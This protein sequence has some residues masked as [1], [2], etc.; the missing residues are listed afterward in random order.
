MKGKGV[1]NGGMGGCKVCRHPGREE[2]DRM[3]LNGTPYANIATRMRTVHPSAPPLSPPNLST[4]KNRHLLTQP[5]AVL[6]G[7]GSQ[8]YL[9][10]RVS[11]TL[12]VPKDN[13]PSETPTLPESLRIVINA[14]L[15]NI[16]A[17]PELVTPRVLMEALEVQRKIGLG[18]EDSEA[19]MAAW[20][21]LGKVQ[22]SQKTRRRRKVT[23]E[24][25]VVGG[26][27]PAIT[28]VPPDEW[29]ADEVKT[30]LLLSTEEGDDDGNPSTDDRATV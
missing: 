22:A 24:E 1:I 21:E 30:A 14:G 7:D 20:E 27:A 13:I 12:I 28:V 3:L 29:A 17:H 16:L 18:G 2:I 9:T 15:R 19:W 6:E 25:E 8:G 5:I 10:A 11:T 23:V 26:G 4:H